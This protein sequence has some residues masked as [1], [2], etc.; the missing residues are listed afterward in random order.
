MPAGSQGRSVEKGCVED[1]ISRGR[2][3]TGVGDKLGTEWRE[4]K[5]SR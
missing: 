4:R 2:A 1:G 3:R 5:E